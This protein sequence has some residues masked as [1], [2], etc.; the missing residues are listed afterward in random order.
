MGMPSIAYSFYP[1]LYNL[2]SP[3]RPYYQKAVN[4]IGPFSLFAFV[5]CSPD[6]DD[7]LRDVLSRYFAFLDVATADRMLFYAPIDEPP[8]WRQQRENCQIA[9]SLFDFHDV[10]RYSCR[11]QD[12]RGTEHALAVTLGIDLQELPAIILT[13]DPRSS[14]YVV[15]RT[16]KD[17]VRQQLVALG[18]FAQDI[19]SIRDRA[20]NAMGYHLTLQELRQKRLDA[21]G[22]AASPELIDSLAEALHQVLSVALVNEKDM[23]HVYHAG[24]SSFRVLEKLRHQIDHARKALRVIE[25][26]QNDAEDPQEPLRVFQLYERL[27]VYMALAESD[28]SPSCP[29]SDTP[30]GWDAGSIRWLILGDR[31]EQVLGRTGSDYR[32]QSEPTDYSPAAVCWSKAFE[33]ELNY[34]LAHW[35]REILG[36]Q[37]PSY[38]GKVQDGIQAVFSSSDSR[39]RVDFNRRR[40]MDEDAWKPPELGLLQGPVYY[41]FKHQQPA[42]LEEAKQRIL[43]EKWEEVRQVRND[44]CHPYPVNRERANLIRQALCELNRQSVLSKLVRLKRRLRGEPEESQPTAIQAADSPEGSRVASERLTAEAPKS[45]GDPAGAGKRPW[46]KF[47]KGE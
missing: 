21:C 18:D 38:Y 17:H 14:E 31:V 34:S 23:G 6:K 7:G 2:A 40:G 27:A 45:S 8:E 9:K 33:A 35:V 30:D 3:S 11:S 16:S 32:P 37:L 47:W 12:P 15:L 28:L 46:W 41:Y 1:L 20:E 44:V 5:L 25:A 42:P 13:T 19:S 24:Y 43:R 36:I 26:A 4:A 39:F 29:G 22:G 10:I